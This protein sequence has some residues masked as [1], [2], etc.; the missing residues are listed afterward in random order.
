VHGPEREAQEEQGEFS[1]VRRAAGAL[2]M[3][4]AGES[5]RFPAD[6]HSES[7]YQAPSRLRRLCECLDSDATVTTVT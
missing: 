6:E 3:V 1:G 5:D 2:V 4:L 7:A